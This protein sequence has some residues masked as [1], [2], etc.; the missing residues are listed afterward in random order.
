MDQCSLSFGH[1]FGYVCSLLATVHFE[2]KSVMNG[3]E[4][5]EPESMYSIMAR[6]FQIRYIFG[7]VL[8][9][10][11]CISA[12][13]PSSSLSNSSAMLLIHSIFFFCYVLL[14]AIFYSQ[15]VRFLLHPVVRMFSYH[16]PQFV[17]RISFRCF[18]MFCFVCIVSPFL[19]IFLIFLLTQHFLVYFLKL[20]AL[21]FLCCFF[22]F[23]FFLFQRFSFALSFLPVFVDFCYLRFQSNFPSRF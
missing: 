15:I 19:D 14:F 3:G 9:K 2:Y 20:F 5:L 1:P 8:S 16:L 23:C 6:R 18:G 13:R 4:F 7:V 11:M 21:I 12:F 22:P 10:S 17:G